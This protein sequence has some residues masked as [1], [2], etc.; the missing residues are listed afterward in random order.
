MRL[1]T[2][3][4]TLLFSSVL[5]MGFFIFKLNDQIVSIDLLFLDLE[6]SIGKMVLSSFLTGIIVTALLELMYS[7]LKKKRKD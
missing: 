3:I 6:T 4:L 7:F 2:L 1:N 5:L